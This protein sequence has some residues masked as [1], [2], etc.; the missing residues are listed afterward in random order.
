LSTPEKKSSVSIAVDETTSEE[1]L[2]HLLQA[3]GGKSELGMFC[4]D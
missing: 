1:D 4:K 2:V 3:A